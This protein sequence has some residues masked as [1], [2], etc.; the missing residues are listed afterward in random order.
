MSMAQLDHVALVV[1]HLETAVERLRDHCKSAAEQVGPIEAFPSEGTREVYVGS[2][3]ARLLLMEPT[4]A[5]GPYSD[6]L[7]KRGPGLH[8]VAL[9]TP[10]L[11]GFIESL[12]GWLLHPR[13]LATIASSR[14]A[15]LAR[16]GVPTLIEVHE[17][18]PLDEL[19]L[20]SAVEIPADLGALT[21]IAGLSS[22]PD[23]HSWITVG[24][25]RVGVVSLVSGAN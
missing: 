20:V 2:G 23:G 8:H 15:W 25:V 4:S 11:D 7:A 22:S 13:S 5:E 1:P 16:P 17:A 14:T 21:P 3:G 18:A 12:H 10:D 19:D 6:A 24:G 9:T